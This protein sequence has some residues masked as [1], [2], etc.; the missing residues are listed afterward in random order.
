MKREDKDILERKEKLMNE[1]LDKVESA[2]RENPENLIFA[3]DS[4]RSPYIHFGVKLDSGDKA[5]F[6]VDDNHLSLTIVNN[7]VD[8]TYNIMYYY[9]TWIS[10]RH[11]FKRATRV[12]AAV[13]KYKDNKEQYD[14]LNMLERKV[15]DVDKILLGEEEK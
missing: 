5:C 9:N 11:I 13:K 3:L 7:N 10:Y 15:A 1:V 8:H 6:Y 14:L 12:K 4:R 2:L